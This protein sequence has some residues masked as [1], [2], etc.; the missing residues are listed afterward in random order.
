MARDAWSQDGALLKEMCRSVAGGDGMSEQLCVADSDD[1]YGTER[2]GIQM[3]EGYVRKVV[4]AAL[5]DG[6]L[7]TVDELRRAAADLH[8]SGYLQQV[9]AEAVKVERATP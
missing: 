5:P 4:D 9:L 2:E 8:L 3:H 6:D 7:Y 1:F